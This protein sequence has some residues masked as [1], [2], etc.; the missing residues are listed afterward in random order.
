MYF[1][2]AEYSKLFPTIDDAKEANEN[3]T[4][5]NSIRDSVFQS[6]GSKLFSAIKEVSEKDLE[7]F[8]TTVLPTLFKI[9]PTAFWHAANPLVEDIA[10]NMFEKGKKENNESLQNAARYLSD[11][12]FGKTGIAEGKETSIVKVEGQDSEVV[13]EREILIMFFL[14]LYVQLLLIE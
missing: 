13:K 10:R 2:E 12:F 4:A 11:Y 1:R 6:D 7:K 9:H 8:S 14:I 5:F 3:N